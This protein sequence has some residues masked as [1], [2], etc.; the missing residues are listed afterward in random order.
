MGRVLKLRRIFGGR[1]GKAVEWGRR[2]VPMTWRAWFSPCTGPAGERVPHRQRPLARCTNC[3]STRFKRWGR[4]NALSYS[5]RLPQCARCQTLPRHRVMRKVMRQLRRKDFRR[6]RCLQ[7]STDPTVGR[8][9]FKSYE[10]SIHNGANSLDIQDIARPDASYDIVVCNHV[11]EHVPDHRRALREL[12]RILSARGFL[13]LSV[14]DPARRAQTEDWARPDPQRH[15]H[16]REFG[17]DFADLLKQELPDLSIIEVQP[18]DDATGDPDCAYI[19]TRSQ[20]W[21]R[22]VR[23]L[24][25]KLRIH[26]RRP[27]AT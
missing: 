13:F 7:I 21:F 5:G 1:L 14:P 25:F 17:P 3:G 24:P 23:A 2:L 12:G 11:V 26:A 9:W 22:R 19:L 18:V 6:A 27:F 20:T 10:V 8:S 4:G 16:Y 15:H